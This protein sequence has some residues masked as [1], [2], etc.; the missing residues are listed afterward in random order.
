M[1]PYPH[2]LFV[3]KRSHQP[4]V[5]MHRRRRYN[6]CQHHRRRHS[7]YIIIIVITS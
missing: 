4:T 2:L 6:R 3:F 7:Q 5:R 1:Q